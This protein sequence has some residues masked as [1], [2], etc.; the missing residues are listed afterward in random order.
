MLRLYIF[1]YGMVISKAFDGA[2]DT[3]TPTIINFFI[4]WTLQL[5][6]AYVLSANFAMGPSGVF[7]AIA[8]TKVFLSVVY[9]TFFQQGRWK[10][11]LI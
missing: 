9:V 3:R 10:T 6:L 11:I 7:L 4:N 1:A 5:P 8:V 2:G